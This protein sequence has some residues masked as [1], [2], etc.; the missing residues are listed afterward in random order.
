M[1]LLKLTITKDARIDRN[2]LAARLESLCDENLL[3]TTL[4][5]ATL[6]QPRSATDALRVAAA[7]ALRDFQNF[8]DSKGRQCKVLAA[9]PAGAGAGVHL[10][11][12]VQARDTQNVEYSTLVCK[13]DASKPDAS[14]K[15]LESTYDGQRDY[16]DIIDALYPPDLQRAGTRYLYESD[17]RKLL[18]GLLEPCTLPLWPGLWLVLT[19]QA[20]ALCSRLERACQLPRGTVQLRMLGLDT[21]QVTRH[22]LASELADNFTAQCDKLAE[23]LEFTAPNLPAIATDYAALCEKIMLAEGIL[24]CEIPCMER[25]EVFEMALIT[26]QQEGK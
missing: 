3:D 10:H 26:K 18:Q 17:L 21:S 22:A 19:D 25:L 20:V 9:R 14:D 15:A 7:D 11:I 13:L 4:Y 1:H 6:P 16:P 12:N 8:T 5:L 2:E 24:G 23:R